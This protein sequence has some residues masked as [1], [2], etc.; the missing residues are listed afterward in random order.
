MEFFGIM[1]LFRILRRKI[2]LF[3]IFRECGLKYYSVKAAT[4]QYISDSRRELRELI[5]ESP[6]DLL[7][8][9]L[10]KTLMETQRELLKEGARSTP[11]HVCAIG[12]LYS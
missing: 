9:M 2:L 4:P 7:K 8:E 10:T 3:E 1:L 5:R 11:R 12:T 6:K